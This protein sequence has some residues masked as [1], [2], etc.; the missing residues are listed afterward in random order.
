MHTIK[1]IKC[2]S[3]TVAIIVQASEASIPSN[4]ASGAPAGGSVLFIAV[5][6]ITL[7]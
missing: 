5:L 2:L 1:D 4:I 7:P 3:P 6:F